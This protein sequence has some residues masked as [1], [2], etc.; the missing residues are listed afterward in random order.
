MEIQSATQK[1]D[2]K[3]KLDLEEN[4]SWY[5]AHRDKIKRHASALQTTLQRI[6][7]KVMEGYR[8]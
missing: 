2:A 3:E 4:G 5:N 6:R 1:F 7:A 8:L